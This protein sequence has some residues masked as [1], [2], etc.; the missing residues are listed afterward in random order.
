MPIITPLHSPQAQESSSGSDAR[1]RAI[2]ILQ[3]GQQDQPIVQ[4]QNK[5][6]PEE[7]SAVQAPETRQE[8]K[9]EKTGSEEKPAEVTKPPEEPLSAQFAQLARKEKAIRAKVQ[10]LKAKEAAIAAKD[11]EYAAKDTEYKSKYISRDAITQDP[12]SVLADLGVTYDQLTQQALSTV[13]QDPATK[14]Y[15]A[16][17]EAKI[18][19][20]EQDNAGTKKTF[21]DN[22]NQQY[23][24]AVNQ[25]RSETK[26]LVA[27]DP[28]YETIRE[29]NSVDDVVDL[30][31][32][33]FKKDGVLLT[34]E[35]AAQEVENHLVDEALK[36]AR[37]KKIQL[38]L[39]PQ[40]TKQPLQ[41]Q[42]QPQAKTLTNAMG[43]SR[44]MSA[45]ERAILAFQ[46][47]LNKT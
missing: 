37:I 43:A 27:S 44:Q 40:E 23:N 22:Q 46:G 18:Q 25:I 3:G 7:L 32:Q 9:D 42:Q 4:D 6:S 10:E 26:A 2:A 17:L 41:K 34:V 45:K 35:E 14:A 29:T 13:Q 19:Q 38:K 11:A 33:T 24:Q 36:I 28:A 12:W 8:Y 20:L 21:Q 47:K 16:K 39:A 5:I 31:E 30:I 1:A 15:L